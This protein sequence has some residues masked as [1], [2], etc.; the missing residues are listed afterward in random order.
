MTSVIENNVVQRRR[1]SQSQLFRPDS[2]HDMFQ[3]NSIIYE[4]N[5]RF[6]NKIGGIFSLLGNNTTMNRSAKAAFIAIAIL[7]CFCRLFNTLF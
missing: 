4:Y 3:D 6:W 2:D 5:N 7:V 1:G